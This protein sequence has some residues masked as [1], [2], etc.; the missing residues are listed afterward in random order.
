L[1]S[2]SQVPVRHWVEIIDEALTTVPM[3]SNRHPG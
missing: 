2:G 3:S 1:Q